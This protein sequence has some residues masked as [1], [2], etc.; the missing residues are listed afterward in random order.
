[1]QIYLPGSLVDVDKKSINQWIIKESK[2]FKVS[3]SLA[4]D[5][6]KQVYY[7]RKSDKYTKNAELLAEE[8]SQKFN[9]NA[10]DKRLWE[11]LDNYVPKFAVENQFVLPKLKMSGDNQ[12]VPSIN[13]PKLKIS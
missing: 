6:L 13:L 12:S 1:M 4:E 2:W 11:I 10:M 7:A 9:L 3:Y 5:K 8:N